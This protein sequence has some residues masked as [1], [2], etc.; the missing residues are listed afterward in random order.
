MKQ[1]AIIEMKDGYP[2]G[3]L[4]EVAQSEGEALVRKK[5]TY[6]GPAQLEIIKK[7][8]GLLDKLKHDQLI[9]L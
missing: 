5:L 7:M 2:F 4:K 6:Q 3:E 9:R 1:G 8:I